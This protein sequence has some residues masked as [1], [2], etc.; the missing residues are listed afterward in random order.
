[1]ATP[2]KTPTRKTTPKE[3]E[4]KTVVNESENNTTV[5][6]LKKENDE[7]K[8]MILELKKMVE[9]NS[10]AP[11]QEK[12]KISLEEEITVISLVPHKLNLCT[13]RLGNGNIYEFF[14]M[15]EEQDIP[16]GDLKDIV[17]NNRKMVDN[18]KF[19]IL[20]DKAVSLLRLKTTYKKLLTPDDIKEIFRAKPN[21]VVELFN[22]APKG[23]Q[24]IIVEILKNKQLN[25]GNVDLNILDTIGK[26]A[27]VDLVNI[28]NPN[29]IP[30]DGE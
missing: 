24:D 25:H 6:S 1:M 23:Q 18:G 17:R 8:S 26:L 10:G 11:V 3:P 4:N 20:D 16:W 15:Y 21:K 13:E 29:D 30:L 7:L 27:N 5:E 28:E 12:D 19:Y 22:L 2:R 9:N 14:S